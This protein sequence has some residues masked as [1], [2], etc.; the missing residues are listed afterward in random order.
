[1]TFKSLLLGALLALSPLSLSK[2][3]EAP[4]PTRY[5]SAHDFPT[6]LQRLRDGL[7]AK[8]LTLFATIDHRAEAEKLGLNLQPAT[9]LIFGNPAVGTPLMRARPALALEL[10][11]KVLIT[12]EDGQTRVYFHRPRD[13]LALDPT[14]LPAEAQAAADKLQA[15]ETL[16]Q[17]LLGP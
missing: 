14:P 15:V 5:T 12:E 4:M 2:P 17:K 1:M 8:G 9:V 6:T 13:L 7:S 16:L 11:L 10:P 3:P